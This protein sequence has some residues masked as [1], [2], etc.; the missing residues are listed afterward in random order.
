M[1]TAATEDVRHTVACINAYLG[2]FRHIQ[3]Q[4]QVLKEAARFRYIATA[5]TEIATAATEIATAATE[6]VRKATCLN[7]QFALGIKT[8]AAVGF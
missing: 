2:T 1:A 5:A 7:R 6:D 3:V 4:R 8:R